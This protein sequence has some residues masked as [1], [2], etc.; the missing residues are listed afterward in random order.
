MKTYLRI[1]KNTWDENFVYR[2]NFIM[3]RLRIVIRFLITY[4]LW[5]SIYSGSKQ[6]F[7]HTRETMLTYV[8]L[9]YIV[10]NFVLATR[11]Q[12]IGAEINEG[13]L[14]NYLLK[15]INY[16]FGLLSRDLG[17]KLLNFVFT[18]IE[19]SLLFLVLKPPLFF[20]TDLMVVIFS[21]F[22]FCGS[23]VLYFCISVL[24]G[25]L[26]FWTTEIWATRFI[27]LILLDYLAGGFFPIDILPPFATN[28][29]LF[30]PF[31]YLFYYP[32]KL[33]LGQ[34]ELTRIVGGFFMIFLWI[35]ILTQLLHVTWKKG[36]RMYSAEGR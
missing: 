19:F 10:S 3:W 31:P 9:V 12:E 11:T 22:A 26:G 15:P 4:F 13:K 35:I 20:Q 34:L 21:L 1:I 29:L 32:V 28:L 17:D 36:L 23:V 2:L 5:S 25:Y 24:I 7:G 33:Y 30:T 6:F 27:F 18:L 8:V 14:T 16:F